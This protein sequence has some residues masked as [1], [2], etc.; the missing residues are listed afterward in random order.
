VSA[1]GVSAEGVSA[2]G[3]SAEGVSAEGVSAEGVSAEDGAHRLLR[4]WCHVPFAGAAARVPVPRVLAVVAHPDDEVLGLGARMGCVASEL[5]VAYVSDGAP[6]DPRFYRPLGFEQREHY[7][8]AR[9]AEARRALGLAGVAEARVHELRVTDQQVPQALDRVVS[10]L[11]ALIRAI[12]PASVLTHAYEGGHPDHDATA[13]AVHVALAR[14]GADRD[15]ALW[16]LP[17][18]HAQGAELIRGQF[19]ADASAREE[20]VVLDAAARARKRSLIECHATQRDF[21]STFPLEVECF[22]LAPRYDFTQP[23]AAP[24]FYDR[25]DW[26]VSGA[27]FLTAARQLLERRGISQPC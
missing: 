6:A 15:R 13:C 4:S 21:C 18:Y 16:E 7:A 2:E 22:R 25:V 26:G 24:F 19:I 14:L 9:R 1:E 11:E 23:P 5:H 12:A 27:M 20:R 17:S 8:S 10:W 3:V